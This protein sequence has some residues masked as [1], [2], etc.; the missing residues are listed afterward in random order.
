M[1]IILI[2]ISLWAV[3]AAVC[4]AS[5]LQLATVG[6]NSRFSTCLGPVAST[7]DGTEAALGCVG[8][9]SVIGFALPE[10]MSSQ[11]FA[12]AAGNAGGVRAIIDL[13]N[14]INRGAV[15]GEGGV[16]FNLDAETQDTVTF[17]AGASAIFTWS[18]HGHVINNLGDHA[19]S[20]ETGAFGFTPILGNNDV[21]WSCSGSCPV[22]TL[23]PGIG[24]VDDFDHTLSRQ[25]F[26]TPGQPFNWFTRMN[27]NG[28][29]GVV[30]GPNQESEHVDL[31]F[32]DPITV[33]AQVFD[34]QGNLL[35]GVSAM[36]ALGID[37]FGQPASA[38]PEPSALAFTGS[39]FFVALV[40]VGRRRPRP[41]APDNGTIA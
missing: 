4:S 25:I 13:Q 3:F 2:A 41:H 6:F 16:Q 9:R 10:T 32:L 12:N 29:V 34:S 30:A 14:A 20:E 23:V 27:L 11:S 37:Y 15:P 22:G 39:V 5:S 8:G 7:N 1:K 35:T 31:D 33:T 18:F 17:S 21:F 36:S 19:V 24:R 28:F 40:Y 38:V 26:F